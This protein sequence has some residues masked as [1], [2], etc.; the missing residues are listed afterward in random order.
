MNKRK[1]KA[2]EVEKIRKVEQDESR[3]SLSWLI[4]SFVGS[5]DFIPG[6]IGSY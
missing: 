3:A 1:I 5:I 4:H 2:A 6:A